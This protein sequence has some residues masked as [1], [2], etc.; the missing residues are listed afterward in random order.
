MGK[1]ECLHRNLILIVFAQFSSRVRHVYIFIFKDVIENAIGLFTMLY[2]TELIVKEHFM[3]RLR[4]S[5][6]STGP[7]CR[8]P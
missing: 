8:R 1:D 4:Y 6:K 7:G 5:T 3:V 2:A